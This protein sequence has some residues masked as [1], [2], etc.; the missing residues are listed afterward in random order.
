MFTKWPI[1]STSII[2][3]SLNGEPTDV[4][5]GDWFVGKAVGSVTISHPILGKVQ[6]FNTHVSVS[7]LFLSA[8][9]HTPLALCEGWGRWP[10]I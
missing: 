5:G 4:T 1:I 10:R 3:Y 9:A 7:M 6:I 2:P 8:V